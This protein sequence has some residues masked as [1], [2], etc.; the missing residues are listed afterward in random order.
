MDY[1]SFP[2]V[3]LCRLFA[4]ETKIE[5][6]GVSK[7]DW[8]AIK[9]S[10][11]ETYK[12]DEDIALLEA[13][14][15]SVKSSLEL[16]K[17]IA[18]IKY[19]LERKPESWEDYFKAANIKYTGN[20]AKDQKYLEKQIQKLQT[21]SEV[22]EARAKKLNTEIKESKE[23]QDN[24]PVSV[25]QAYKILA[26]LNHAGF[27]FSDYEKVTCGEQEAASEVI[28]DLNKKNG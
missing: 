13:Y 22:M 11:R 10:Y 18:V 4:D 5:E 2:F 1:H 7:E 17:N 8:E 6:L 20:A 23:R 19:I 15:A 28:K 21:K 3:K 27:S 26:S 16:N 14:K 12:S 9:E 24:K 25:K